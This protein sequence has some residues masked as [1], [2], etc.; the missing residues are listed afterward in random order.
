ML[1]VF[2][3]DQIELLS[4]K[5]LTFVASYQLLQLHVYLPDVEVALPAEYVDDS[6]VVG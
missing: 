2:Q 5:G 4:Y 3:S 6:G 1:F